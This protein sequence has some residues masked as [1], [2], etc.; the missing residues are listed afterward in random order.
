MSGQDPRV[1]A[2][3]AMFADFADFTQPI[4]EHLRALIHKACPEVDE[5]IQWSMPF[6]SHRGVTK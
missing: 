4:P 1:D 6:F 3:I 5:S 2:Y